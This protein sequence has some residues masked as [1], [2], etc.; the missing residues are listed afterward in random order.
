MGGQRGAN[1]VSR[2]RGR[3]AHAARRAERRQLEPGCGP[4]FR[5]GRTAAGCLLDDLLHR[6]QAEPARPQNLDRLGAELVLVEHRGDDRRRRQHREAQQV[7][8]GVDDREYLLADDLLCRQAQLLRHRPDLHLHRLGSELIL[9]QQRRHLEAG[10]SGHWLHWVASEVR[11]ARR[12]RHFH[13]RWLPDVLPRRQAEQVRLAGDQLSGA[14]LVGDL[15]HVGG[16]RRRRHTEAQQVRRRVG[17]RDGL[18]RGREYLL[19]RIAVERHRADLRHEPVLLELVE[20]L[21]PARNR[22][23]A[24]SDVTQVVIYRRWDDHLVRRQAEPFRP[25]DPH[26]R[27]A[28]LVLVP[29]LR[30]SRSW[31]HAEAQQVRGPVNDLGY[32]AADALRRWQAQLLRYR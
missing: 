15:N 7:R 11:Q 17:N 16:L 6:R 24:L 27:G 12:L 18:A 8:Y 30:P 9:E 2:H 5:P 32:L 20:Q 22:V 26:R 29:H 4:A 28:E 10:R 14:E 3:K 23:L 19:D 25:E 13:V 21:D 31:R 1:S